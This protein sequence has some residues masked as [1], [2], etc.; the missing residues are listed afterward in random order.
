MWTG[1]KPSLRHLAVWGCNAQIRVPNPYRTK[2][3]FKSTPEIFIGYSSI[4]KGYHFYGP[5]NDKLVES[6]DAIFLDQHT[7]CRAKWARVE[8]L[9]TPNE[10][11]MDTSGI[12]SHNEEVFTPEINRDHTPNTNTVRRSGRNTHAPSYL[13]DY[14]VFLG[15]VHSKISNLVEDPKSYKEATNCAQSKLWV[16]AMREEL[17]SMRKNNVWELVNLPNNRKPIGCKWIFKR[18]LNAAGQVEKYK[19]RF[20]AKGF[21]QR[22]G[23]DFV[24]TFSP[25]AKFTSIRIFSALTAYYDLELHQMDVKTTFLNGHL[26]EEIYMLQPEGFGEKGKENMVCMLNRSI[27]GLK[28]A[29]R[30]WYILFDNAITSYG[31]SMTEVDHCIYTK[32]IG[33]NFVLLSLYVDD[34]LIASNDKNYIGGS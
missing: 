8:L 26:E 15:E 12:N 7:P 24:E 32:V 33:S 11:Q 25:V 18:K 10:L 13:D 3:Q 1:R 14:Y 5:E 31:F 16:E 30:Q 2:L 22:E 21:T 34:I 23:V 19:A 20:V 4:S 17:N 29:S 28:Q 9:A 6:R 27:Y